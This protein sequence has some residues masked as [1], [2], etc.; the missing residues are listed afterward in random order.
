MTGREGR[1]V[2][3]MYREKT[4]LWTPVTAEATRQMMNRLRD[5]REGCCWQGNRFFNALKVS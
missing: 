1:T 5:P 4:S 3:N 2:L